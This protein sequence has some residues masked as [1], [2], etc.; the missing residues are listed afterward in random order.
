[1]TKIVQHSFLGGQLDFE[2]MGRQDIE[3]YAKGATTLRNFLPMKRGGLRKRP[4]TDL[5][6]DVTERVAS[7]NGAAR[8]VPFAYTTS[9]GWALLFTPGKILAVSRTET[10]EV[11]AEGDAQFYSAEQIAALDYCQSGD[12]VFLAE[13][14]HAPCRIEHR[15]LL[16]V[17]A[18]TLLK[19][20]FARRAQG[21]PS[22]TKATVAKQATIAIG[23]V[24]TEQYSATAVFD[25]EET[26]PCGVYSG[27]LPSLNDDC[28]DKY[29]NYQRQAAAA[30]FSAVDY[31]PP[32]RSFTS[33]SYHAPWTESQT[34][35]L[36]ITARARTVDGRTEYP[37]QVRVYRKSGSFFG[38]VG[39]AKLE[40]TDAEK[41]AG[42]KTVTWVDRYYT[43]DVSLTPP[44]AESFMDGPGEWPASVA[45][46]QQRLVW[47]STA[48]DPSR[49]LMSQVGD[50]YTYA[51]HDAITEDDPIDF[52]VSST[53][54]PRINH[55]VEMRKLILFN[56]DAEWV[57]DSASASAGITYATIQ[58]RQH[59]AIGAAPWLKPIVCNNVLLFAERTGQAVRQYGYQLED[60]GYGGIDVSIF[61]SSIFRG[62]RIVSW[63]FRQ[64][65]EPTCWCVLSDGGMCSLTF[66]PEQQT[67]AWA[68]HS[69]GGGARA[70][71]VV[72]THALGGT[73]E[74]ADTTEALL[75]VERGGRWTVEAMRSDC[76][77][78]VDSV[79]NAL[80]MD[81][82]RV[83]Q[84]GEEPLG[85]GEVA[86]DPLT[87]EVRGASAASPGDY[88]GY[89]V[90]SEFTS[91]YPVTREAVGLAQMDVKCIQEAHL[92]VVDAVGG[93]VRA[94]TV[95]AA[96]ASRLERTGLCC[97]GEGNVELTESDENVPLVTDNSRDGRVTIEQGE[98]WPF[99]LLMLETDLELEYR[100]REG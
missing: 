58:A 34:I 25:D 42:T 88:A 44:K 93:T 60:D 36:T 98:P 92:R 53:R 17:H 100:E 73:G 77:H 41:A 82:L 47:A 22:I 59:S 57:V 84:P 91:V 80:C 85:D 4:G 10:V 71:G 16:G 45:I 23:S 15:V 63:A 27:R 21:V 79:G 11:V 31:N 90:K 3:K 8:L 49:V 66:M 19:M 70:R 54:F 62:R 37:E 81:S 28:T 29:E 35:T 83:V 43:P 48:N 97:D 46:S 74:V 75:L 68:T 39:F 7:G 65:P 32:S 76:A 72:C 50:F 6:H 55:L 1:M 38:L 18:F 69:L 56:G 26:N 51:A 96:E 67:V 13:Q 12:V 95:G 52:K 61:S 24:V 64:H 5:L 33:T 30:H 99:T 40:W 9:E 86:V 94:A 87:G 2:L 78:R 14:T 20:D 89:P